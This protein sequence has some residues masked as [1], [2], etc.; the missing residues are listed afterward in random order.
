M[1][2][3]KMCFDEH[4]AMGDATLFGAQTAGFPAECL[5]FKPFGEGSLNYLNMFEPSNNNTLP[6]LNLAM[7]PPIR[8]GTE[9]IRDIVNSEHESITPRGL[10]EPRLP[11]PL[12]WNDIIDHDNMPQEDEQLPLMERWRSNDRR[13]G[14]EDRHDRSRNRTRSVR[15]TT[16]EVRRLALTLSC[17]QSSSTN[18]SG[19]TSW[20]TICLRFVGWLSQQ[21]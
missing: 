13:D 7:E 1:V 8:E 10:P 17:S 16:E 12:I 21:T 18:A 3:N 20:T 15:T 5:R 11:E 14:K 19:T 6:T 9:M 2:T 4:D